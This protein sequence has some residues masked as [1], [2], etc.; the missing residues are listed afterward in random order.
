MQKVLYEIDPYNRLVIN[1]NGKKSD[2]PKFRRTLDGKF[3]TDEL[4]NLS[5]HIKHPLSGKEKVPNQIRLKGEWSLT[6]NHELK[7]TFDKEARETFG[8]SI[9]VQGEILDVDKNSILF[10]L[11]TRTKDNTRSTYVLILD[12]SWKADANNR[13]SFHIRK[14][15]GRHDVLT[16]NGAWQ[17][18][19]TH[20]II[21]EYEK[22]GLVRK[23]KETHT[24]TFRGYW[25]IRENMRI[26]YVLSADTGSAFNFKTSAGI[27]S[28]D[29]IK[30]EVGLGLTGRARP[31]TRTIMLSGR[32]NI[33]KDADVTFEIEY[34]KKKIK[35]INFGAALKLSRKISKG[36]GE[37][38]L[39]ALIS[40]QESAVY[41]GAGW[42]W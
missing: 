8:D 35:A 6:D 30:Y 2:L 18:N 39:R 4:N 28:K 34:E 25:D 40:K 3:K 32:W 14:E 15:R 11:T 16:F 37:V 10:A 5:Y 1:N 13:L 12:G 23:K 9:T 24:L 22:A 21:Y 38:F 26:S 29:Y 20:Q 19:K 31:L 36:D 42:R 7:L 17:I 33:K 41:A 27:F